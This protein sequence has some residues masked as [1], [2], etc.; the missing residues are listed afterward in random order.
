MTVSTKSDLLHRLAESW[1]GLDAKISA[2]SEAQLTRVGPDGWSTKDHLA[3]ISAWE[4]SLIA[5]LEGRDRRAAIG[6]VGAE[7][8]ST[9]DDVDAINA[10]IQRRSQDRSLADVLA[11]FRETH[12]QCVS[13]I[14]RLSDEDLARPYSHFQPNDPANSHPVIGWIA[15]NTYE[16]Y[17][18]H[19]GWIAQL[20]AS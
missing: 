14:A 4:G 10:L 8:E 11:A 17:D 20:L 7:A 12:R 15:G 3:H 16:H 1:L 5:L 18:E 9:G 6:L 19:A 13:A 2:L